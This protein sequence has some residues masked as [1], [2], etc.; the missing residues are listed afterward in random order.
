MIGSVYVV[1]DDEAVRD[2]LSEMLVTNNLAVQTYP[3]AYAFM[4]V[5]ATLPA[6]VV[7]SDVRMPGDGLELQ[8]LMAVR[9]PIIIITGHGDAALAVRAMRQG[10]VDFLEKPVRPDELVAAIEVALSGDARMPRIDLGPEEAIP[11]MLPDRLRALSRQ[12]LIRA[13]DPL[14]ALDNNPAIG[15]LCLTV[16]TALW[17]TASQLEKIMFGQLLHP[18][19]IPAD[20]Q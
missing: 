3:S 4:D 18:T 14:N 6:G 2:S 20:P 7:V 1:D 17:G 5:A 9:Y 19:L 15:E 13:A 11:T 8:R 16:S 12:W 10:A